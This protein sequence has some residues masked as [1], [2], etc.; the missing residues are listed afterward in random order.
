M[1]KRGDSSNRQK[2]GCFSQYVLRQNVKWFL[3]EY[4]KTLPRRGSVIKSIEKRY[5]PLKNGAK[6]F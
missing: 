6:D 2:N 3:S 1:F 4:R 5:I